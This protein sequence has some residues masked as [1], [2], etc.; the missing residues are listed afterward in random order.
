VSGGVAVDVPEPDD[1]EAPTLTLDGFAVFGGVA[2]G[3]K[4]AAETND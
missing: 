1:P 4:A 3:A 2:V